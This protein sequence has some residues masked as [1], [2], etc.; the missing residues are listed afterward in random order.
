LGGGLIS[1]KLFRWEKEEKIQVRAK[2]W[3]LM[4]L[5]P[6]VV[7]GLWQWLKR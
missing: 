4:V 3:V 2:L 5:L 7:M 1:M 6:F